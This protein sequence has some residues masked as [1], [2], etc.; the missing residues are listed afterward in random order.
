MAWAYVGDDITSG[1]RSLVE[2]APNKILRFEVLVF[3]SPP[4]TAPLGDLALDKLL[5]QCLVVHPLISGVTAL[6][7]HWLG[8][9][10][11]ALLRWLMAILAPWEA[12]L[13]ASSIANNG[14]DDSSR[15]I[16]ACKIHA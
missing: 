16:D 15:I 13:S 5:F 2:G 8:C 1:C 14:V 4:Q 3:I 12:L 10:Y 9:F 7:H 11:I 6:S